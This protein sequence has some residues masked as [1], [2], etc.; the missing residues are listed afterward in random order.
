MHIIEYDEAD[1][2]EESRIR[3]NEDLERARESA[4]RILA[5]AGRS[6]KD[7]LARLVAKGH[8]QDVCEELVHRLEAVG[9]IDEAESASIIVRTR[10][11]ERG[12]S[13]RAIAEE[14]SRKGFEPEA[15]EHAMT[16]ITEDDEQETVLA[17]A[18][19]R[20]SRDVTV[21]QQTRKRRALSH[22]VRK[23]YSPGLAMSCIQRVLDEE[24]NT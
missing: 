14:L 6:K 11:R 2:P 8:E 18:R 12:R 15:I 10:F 9:L 17:L 4:M 3:V 5:S 16:H 22:L 23:G 24:Q 20:L 19:K 21:D 7:V 1:I 13:R